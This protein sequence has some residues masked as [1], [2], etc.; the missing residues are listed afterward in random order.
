LDAI[1]PNELSERVRKDIL[2]YQDSGLLS[3]LIEVQ[4]KEQTKYKKKLKKFVKNL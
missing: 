3:E 1:E 2:S 4:T